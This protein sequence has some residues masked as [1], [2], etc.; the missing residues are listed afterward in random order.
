M[1]HRP[2]HTLPALL[3]C[4]LLFCLTRPGFAEPTPPETVI[5][6]A[7]ATRSE[8][9]TVPEA[10]S[11]ENP[12]ALPAEGTEP[13]PASV[14]AAPGT[15]PTTDQVDFDD[16]PMNSWPFYYHKKLG[17][18][19]DQYVF[20]PLWLYERGDTYEKHYPIW[21]LLGSERRGEN[22]SVD[23]LWFFTGYKQ[24]KGELKQLDLM[25]PF[26]GYES[27]GY[28]NRYSLVRPFTEVKTTDGKITT[29]DLL[30]PF[31]GYET[32]PR[33]TRFRVLWPFAAY[34]K[35]TGGTDVDFL[36]PFSGY[37]D[38]TYTS[39]RWDKKTKQSVSTERYERY[40]YFLRPLIG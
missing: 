11:P 17:R 4:C 5:A 30:W 23:L 2:R 27:T 12:A 37:R 18:N 31:A 19:H 13:P 28:G 26:T 39:I 10:A 16:R 22:K 36:W 24:Q 1:H 6:P 8:A 35:D 34:Q 21:P 29:F 7:Q 32:S 33:E 20:G 40:N 15:R 9:A 38:R 25:W 14:P 3:L